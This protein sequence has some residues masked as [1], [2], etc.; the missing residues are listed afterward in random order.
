MLYNCGFHVVYN[1]EA[2]HLT[3]SKSWIRV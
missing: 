1:V 3:S 2:V